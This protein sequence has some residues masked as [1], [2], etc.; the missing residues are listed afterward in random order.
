MKH[1]STDMLAKL[2]A[3][4]LVCFVVLDMAINGTIY[5]YTDCDIPLVVDGHWYIPTAIK[6]GEVRHEADTMLSS[7]SFKIS[8][9]VV[10][11]T[12][13][14][15]LWT[16][17]RAWNPAVRDWI[18]DSAPKLMDVFI[19][20]TPHKSQIM[21]RLVFLN[22]SYYTAYATTVLTNGGFES[23]IMGDWSLS[24]GSGCTASA[25]VISSD[26]Y[27]GDYCCEVDI[28]DG[29]GDA[30]HIKD[31]LLQQNFAQAISAGYLY[32]FSFAAKASSARY[33][34]ADIGVVGGSTYP[35]FYNISLTTAWQFFNIPYLAGAD[36]AAGNAYV[37]FYLARSD[38]NANVRIDSVR[39][40][41]SLYPITIFRG[42]LENWSLDEDLID[43]QVT[44]ALAG[45]TQQ[46]GRKQSCTCR[47][48]RFKDEECG[49]T[50]DE[51][52]CDRT[53]ARCTA[54]G[55]TANFGGF[56]WL[57]SLIGK[58]IYWGRIPLEQD[59]NILT[60]NYINVWNQINGIG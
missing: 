60:P 1:V 44:S 50:G 40:S 13:A 30:T 27:Q 22:T 31:I 59:P 11:S 6:P 49:Y 43:I 54:L 12:E 26:S 19:N 36:I 45:W 58:T 7:F 15:R 23:G 21:A 24:V 38:S 14:L 29:W 41:T 28:T 33:I 39:V 56:R 9:Q 53:Y 37:N 52:W 42:Y 35:M 20:G 46:T 17:T 4:K 2:Q 47:W 3:G 34:G 8:S 10:T 48:R 25:S 51:T 5:R 18:P 32:D 57:P 16:G 55:N